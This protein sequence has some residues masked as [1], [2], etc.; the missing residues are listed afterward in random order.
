MQAI[1]LKREYV[2]D[3]YYHVFNRG[4]GKQDI[5]HSPEDYEFFISLFKEYL[6]DREKGLG[7]WKRNTYKGAIEV[8]AFC[9]MPNHFHLLI[10]QREERIMSEFMRSICVRYTKYRNKKYRTVGHTFQD[11]FKARHIQSDPD[12]VFL[13]RYIHRNPVE[14]CDDIFTYPYSSL[15]YFLY[16]ARVPIWLSSIQMQE[17]FLGLFGTRASDFSEIYKSFVQT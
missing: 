14:L 10:R 5:F 3:G 1:L 15:Q 16:P 8:I 12:F 4:N 13:S 7:R 11:K 9:L 2:K 6:S 17:M